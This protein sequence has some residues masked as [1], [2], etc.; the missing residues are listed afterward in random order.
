V[1]LL[2]LHW[3]FY[4]PIQSAAML[5]AEP[6]R[7]ALALAQAPLLSSGV[8]LPCIWEAFGV[9]VPVVWVLWSL[10]TGEQLLWKLQMGL[11]EDV[12]L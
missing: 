3:M 7:M 11:L 5:P 2:W 6:P 10:M 12:L 1:Q 9:G 8:P 4:Q